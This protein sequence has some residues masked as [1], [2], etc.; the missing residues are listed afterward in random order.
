MIVLFC[1]ENDTPFSQQRL[2]KRL[3][4]TQTRNAPFIRKGHTAQTKTLTPP[5]AKGSHRSGEIC[6]DSLKNDNDIAPFKNILND[7]YARDIS[8]KIKNAKR[9][10]AKNG[11]QRLA[12]PP[13][14]Y[15]MNPDTPS[16]LLIDPEPAEVVRL[17][18]S[19]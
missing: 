3:Y 17:I 5:E 15:R 7:M 2:Q 6:I 9:Q 11:L 14:G 4:H 12:Q 1:I 16:R 18:F 19:Y 10:R 8:R 13:Y